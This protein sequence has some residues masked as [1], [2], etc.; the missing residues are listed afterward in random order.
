MSS[1]PIY[2]VGVAGLDPRDLR[3][4]EIVFKHSQYNKFEFKLAATVEIDLVDFIIV[5]PLEA[6]GAR[7]IA[8]VASSPVPIPV[9]SA[10]PRGATITAKHTI[11]IDRLTLQLLPIL[12]RVI[13]LEL[14][15]PDTEPMRYPTNSR[16]FEELPEG[17]PM[18]GEAATQRP[19][20]K[21]AATVFPASSPPAVRNPL[22]PLET[23]AQYKTATSPVLHK[24]EPTRDAT[25]PLS[26]RVSA[27]VVAPVPV[28]LATVP[29]LP[30]PL[31]P[32]PMQQESLP[33]RK[34]ENL[35]AAP[36]PPAPAASAP[37]TDVAQR[38]SNKLVSLR[39]RSDAAPQ[40]LRA[41]VVDDS[42]TVRQQL[43][44]ALNKMGFQTEAGSGGAD[45][46][47]RLNGGSHFDLILVDVVM[48]D[49]DGYKLTREIKRH[50]V[51][52]STPVIILTSK[53]SPFDLARGALAGC[54][55]F[56]SKPVPLKALEQGIVKVLRKSL[57]IDDLGSLIKLSEQRA[58]EA[59]AALA[60]GSVASV[61]S[62]LSKSA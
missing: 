4:V 61:S 57:A 48:P 18:P 2:R 33:M 62:G 58:A 54:D 23:M 13:E 49:M 43:V 7:A 31:Q 1:K 11:S 52:R 40:R 16:H 10:I 35:A 47:E 3:L 36:K 42:P 27:P 46:L 55:T 59:A 39:S 56:L 20:V 22:P 50:K 26:P 53:S 60:S 21:T 28:S 25:V 15:G 38:E 30:V 19:A 12:N 14:L 6:S 41:L 9:I 29:V 37:N 5:N 24:T 51:W 17:L 45:A 34:P 44:L 8:L 32:V